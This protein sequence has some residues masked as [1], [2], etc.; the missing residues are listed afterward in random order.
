MSALV[1]VPRDYQRWTQKTVKAVRQLRYKARTDLLWFA[2]HILGHVDVCEAVHGELIRS[3]QQFP[4]P[5]DAEM[6]DLDQFHGFD[7]DHGRPIWVYRPLLPEVL[8]LEGPRRRLILD[9]RSSLKTTLNTMDHT[10]QWLVNYPDISIF[11][12]QANEERALEN[13]NGILGQFRA[14]V[15]FRELFPD[16][17]SWES[18]FAFGTQ[19]SFTTKARREWLMNKHESVITGSITKGAAGKHVHVIKFSDPVDEVNSANESGLRMVTNRFGL[20]E[21]TLISPHHWIDVE[22]TR[23]QHSDL[24]GDLIRSEMKKAKDKRQWFMYVRGWCKKIGP[25][26]EKQTFHDPD[27]LHWDDEIG[28]D[29][30]PI[31]WWPQRVNVDYI[32]SKIDDPSFGDYNVACQYRNNPSDLARRSTKAFS[33]IDFKTITPELFYQN[34]RVV[35]YAVTVDTAESWGDTAAK[36]SDYSAITTCAWDSAG[37]CYVVEIQ[38]GRF[39]TDELV[40]KVFEMGRKYRPQWVRIEETGYVRGFK[41]D[42]QRLIQLDEIHNNVNYPALNFRLIPRDNKKSKKERILL[43]L[44]QPYKRGEIIFLS[45]LAALDWVRAEL[46]MFPGYRHDDVLDTLADQWQDR[47]WFG[48]LTRG[49]GPLDSALT[50]DSVMKRQRAAEALAVSPQYK[51]AAFN[52]MVFGELLEGGAPIP[53]RS[54]LDRTGGL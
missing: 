54:F 20:Y 29:G 27:E 50:F 14:G 33:L 34:V 31:P 2:S 40:Q 30:K 15:K 51:D 28:I 7:P 45:N 21:P 18:P 9:F 1:H 46:D 6:E 41:G 25:S 42:F 4:R 24:Y 26:G 37:R 48:R 22:G 38:H 12:V 36:D 11:L 5:L 13:I 44:Q 49:E 19:S 47:E 35:Y 52:R 53:R 39:S 32:Q 17:V 16:H 3:L 8:D 43:T 23:Y 10:I